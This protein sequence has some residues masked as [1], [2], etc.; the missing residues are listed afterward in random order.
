MTARTLLCRGTGLLAAGRAIAA[1]DYVLAG[2][3]DLETLHSAADLVTEIGEL[4]WALRR[5]GL[6]RRV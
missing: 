3:P 4:G 2:G 6:A 1:A 5:A